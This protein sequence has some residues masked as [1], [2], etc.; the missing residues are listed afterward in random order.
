MNEHS[1]VVNQLSDEMTEVNNT[2][3]GEL[4][5]EKKG[6]DYLNSTLRGRFRAWDLKEELKVELISQKTRFSIS[7]SIRRG[8][9]LKSRPLYFGQTKTS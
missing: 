5:K 1:K 4:Y 7:S 3:L 9:I 2:L 6:V 8:A